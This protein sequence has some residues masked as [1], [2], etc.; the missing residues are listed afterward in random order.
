[1]SAAAAADVQIAPALQV[2]VQRAYYDAM[3][4]LHTALLNVCAD[5]QGDKYSRV[6]STCDGHNLSMKG[7][8]AAVLRCKRLSCSCG[9][10]QRLTECPAPVLV[11]LQLL[12]AY[13]LQGVPPEALAEKVLACFSELFKD[14]STRLVRSTVLAKAFSQ[15]SESGDDSTGSSSAGGLQLDECSFAE[16]CRKV[17]PDLLHPCLSKLQESLYDLLA[18]YHSMLAWHEAGLAEHTQAAAAAAAAAAHAAARSSGHSEGGGSPAATGADQEAADADAVPSQQQLD[19]VQAATKGILTGVQAA[20]QAHRSATAEA[21]AVLVKELLAG[22]GGCTGS[23]FPQVRATFWLFRFPAYSLSRSTSRCLCRDPMWVWKHTARTCRQQCLLPLC[24]QVVEGCLRFASLAEAFTGGQLPTRDA[25]MHILGAFVRGSHK[26]NMQS[27]KQALAVE[28]WGTTTG[29]G[30]AAHSS[31]AS[32]SLSVASVSQSLGS[33]AYATPAF[34][35]AGFVGDF[36][37]WLKSGN[38]FRKQ[39]RTAGS[40][41][42]LDPSG[43]KVTPTAQGGTAGS[44]AAAVSRSCTLVLQWLADY[45]GLMSVLPTQQQLL[46]GGIAELFDNYL[47]ACFVLFSG[48]SLQTLVWQED[49]LLHRL[50]TALLRITTSSSCKYKAEVR[51]RAARVVGGPSEAARLSL[52]GCDRFCASCDKVE[53][54]NARRSALT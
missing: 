35:E 17:T 22:A 46:W 28:T 8:P 2:A 38:P 54:C 21:A 25:F 26:S 14:V 52:P 32:P 53:S 36:S 33:T 49:C 48:V 10:L 47:L 1:V 34:G 13:L 4:H 20:L 37:E 9:Q 27:L 18:S 19:Q 16:L 6:S 15:Q 43:T 12:E 44:S 41:S 31:S 50:R 29:P 30:A 5:F 51:R 24:V 7:C 42:I 45:A 40:R 3:Q 11:L 39:G 23:E